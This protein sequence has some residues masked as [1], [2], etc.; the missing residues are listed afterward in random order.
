MRLMINPGLS[1]HPFH[2]DSVKPLAVCEVPDDS[3]RPRRYVVP[4]QICDLLPICD[5]ETEHSQAVA[6]MAEKSDGGYSRKQLEQLTE[7]FL[8]PRHLL[9]DRD[10]PSK[11][12]IAARRLDRYLFF[13]VRFL[14]QELVRPIARGLVWL[15]RP[16]VWK[17]FV[18]LILVTHLWFYFALLHHKA[19][20]VNA[21]PNS[22]LPW[23]LLLF[24][25]GGMLHEFGHATALTSFGGKSAEIGFGIY[26][27]FA[28]LFVDLSEAWRLTSRQR[29]IID[30]SGM[31]F[32][33]ILL[34]FMAIGYALTGWPALACC[35]VFIDIEIAANLNPLLRLDG[36]W[37]LADGLGIPNLRS[38]SMEYL[39]ASIIGRRRD[40]STLPMSPRTLTVVRAYLVSTLLFSIYLVYA[41][42][43]QCLA[44]VQ[45]YPR[46]LRSAFDSWHT[47]S[48]LTAASSSF[49]A[50]WRG[51]LILAVG[52]AICRAAGWIVSKAR[53]NS[54]SQLNSKELSLP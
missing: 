17:C 21:L 11:P 14:K 50:L 42:A 19:P 5:G 32:Q 4:R 52:T 1:I 35:F 33:G 30:L 15:F 53:W 16:L 34:I 12:V 40:R 45:G 31:Y 24:S 46:V 2:G 3:G 37:A 18:P 39:L 47:A 54:S 22:S 13:K 29:V 7:E 9:L 49:A 28:A 20:Q 26:I 27:C 51:M 8:I 36:Y 38:R 25:L 10:A 6:L 43:M 41:V 44:I 23:L 48:W